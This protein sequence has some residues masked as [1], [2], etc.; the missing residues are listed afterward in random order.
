MISAWFWKHP[1]YVYIQLFCVGVKDAGHSVE[2][3]MFFDTLKVTIMLYLSTVYC[4]TL[5]E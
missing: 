3:D 1:C 5:A 4:I 2:S